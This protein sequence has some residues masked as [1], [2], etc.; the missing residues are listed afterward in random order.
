M[1]KQCGRQK[2]ERKSF[3]DRVFQETVEQ[4][5]A[6]V[7]NCCEVGKDCCAL[8]IL[9]AQDSFRGEVSLPETTIVQ[10]RTTLSPTLRSFTASSTTLRK[11]LLSCIE[12]IFVGKA[13]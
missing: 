7:A 13:R 12:E 10:Q 8:R 1:K 11:A 2:K 3:E 4:S 5:Q 6:R 9:G